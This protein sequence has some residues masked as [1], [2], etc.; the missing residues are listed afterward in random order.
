M[1]NLFEGLEKFGLAKV[2][3]T[4]LFKEEKP[5]VG[6]PKKDEFKIFDYIY[7]K[8]FICPVCGIN[9]RNSMIRSTKLKLITIEPN[10]HPIYEPI[11]PLC[12]DVIMCEN[13]GYSA[14]KQKFN[15]ISDKQ[16]DFIKEKISKNYTT[17]NYPDEITVDMAIERFKMALLNNLIK[18]SPNGEK[19]YI[20]M[21]I[22]WLY[23]LKKDRENELLFINSA[24]DG[25]A[26]AYVNESFPISGIEEN[27]F[28]YLLGY[29]S[30]ELKQ[31]EKSMKFLST[32][33][34]SRTA[35][36]RLKDRARDL[37]DIIKKEREEQ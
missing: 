34:V 37:K 35:S 4:E 23:S 8:E 11:E 27:T 5:A 28:I 17:V 14:L 31:Y 9:F 24:Y 15:S 20:C 19:A 29:F 30:K 7:K 26:K 1:A 2:A 16:I 10:L 18:S 25:F 36:E 21:K 12:Y 3:P 33:I 13:C 22:S 6:A 32:V